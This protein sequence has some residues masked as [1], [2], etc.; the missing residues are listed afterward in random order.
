VETEK[1]VHELDRERIWQAP[2][3]PRPSPYILSIDDDDA[4]SECAAECQATACFT[5]QAGDSVFYATLRAIG[6]MDYAYLHPF[7][8]ELFRQIRFSAELSGESAVRVFGKAIKYGMLGSPLPDPVD[9]MESPNLLATGLSASL[10]KDGFRH[11][12][13]GLAK[14]LCP[15]KTQ[16]VLGV[17]LSVPMYYHTY[18]RERIAISAHPLASQPVVE[19]CLRVPTYVLLADGKSRGLARRTFSD[20]LPREVAHR[21]VKATGAMYW[22][23]F[24]R[25]NISLLRECLLDG[26]LVRHGILDRE[27]LEAYLTEEQPFLTVQPIK[28]MQYL[29]C[30]AW[31]RQ[32]TTA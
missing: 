7:G 31:V 32:W 13:A 15:G 4:E 20:L 17:A 14:G 27:K 3:A 2:L 12:W 8:A 6:A 1:R 28:I 23:R 19:A 11:P 9:P 30:E 21:L 26:A 24:V 18:Y 22:P 16:H 25:R 29:G 5:G 10:P